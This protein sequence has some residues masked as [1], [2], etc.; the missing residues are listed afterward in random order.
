MSVTIDRPLK[1]SRTPTGQEPTIAHTSP[2]LP[3]SLDMFSTHGLNGMHR[4]GIG[5]IQVFL[6][7]IQYYTHYFFRSCGSVVK[8]SALQILGYE[9]FEYAEDRRFYPCHD[10]D[11]PSAVDCGIRVCCNFLFAALWPCQRTENV[12]LS[13]FVRSVLDLT[14]NGSP[15]L[16]LVLVSM[17]MH[18]ILR[19]S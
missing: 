7:V 1:D 4:I 13:L 5:E 11:E 8:E 16:S 18:P 9:S 12:A 10:Q 3:L 17:S 19:D 14:S 6:Y 2:H 15:V